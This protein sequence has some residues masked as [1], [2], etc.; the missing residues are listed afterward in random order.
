MKKANSVTVEEISGRKQLEIIPDDA[1]YK[2]SSYSVGDRVKDLMTYMTIEEK[3]A[4][5]VIAVSMV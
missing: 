3:A 4:Q 1:V 5:M 2:D